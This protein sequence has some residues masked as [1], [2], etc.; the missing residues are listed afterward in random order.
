MTD[1]DSFADVNEVCASFFAHE[2]PA[3]VTVGVASLPKGASVEVDAI[4]ALG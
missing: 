1:L 4:V 3:R 2:P